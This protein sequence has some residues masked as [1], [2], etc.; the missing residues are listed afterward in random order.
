MKRSFPYHSTM[1]PLNLKRRQL[2][3]VKPGR[4]YEEPSIFAPQPLSGAVQG[5]TFQVCC[6]AR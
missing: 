1:A 5:S 6:C 3:G 4:D 2:E